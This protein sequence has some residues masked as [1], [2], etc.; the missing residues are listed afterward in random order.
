MIRDNNFSEWI[1]LVQSEYAEMPGLQLSKR[2]AERL[3]NIAPFSA[4][5]ILRALE[6]A[7]FLRRTPNDMYVRA[8]LGS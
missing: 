7:N 2:Q 5:V 1:R 6:Q 4:D 3:W 8:D